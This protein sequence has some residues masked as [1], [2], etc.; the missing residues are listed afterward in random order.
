MNKNER[1]KKKKNL[2][3]VYIIFSIYTINKETI[4]F[5]KQ[6][7]RLYKIFLQICRWRFTIILS[8]A[9]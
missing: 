3:D 9:L 4:D 8:T 5:W 1:K 6:G 7:T 2:W